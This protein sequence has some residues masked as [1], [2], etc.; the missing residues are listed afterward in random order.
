MNQPA[1]L[2]MS[3]GGGEKYNTVID[4]ATV[5]T[6][7]RKIETCFPFSI[8]SFNA[9]LFLYNHGDQRIFSI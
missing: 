9:A 1:S 7:E 5:L 6:F 3:E 8:N 2:V 4:S